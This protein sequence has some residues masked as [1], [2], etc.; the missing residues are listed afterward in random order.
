MVR[1]V[2]TPTGIEAHAGERRKQYENKKIAIGRLRRKL[3]V[4][5]RITGISVRGQHRGSRYQPS[6]LW[7]SRR[8]GKQI[9]INPRHA[10]FPALLAEALD[11]VVAR[12]G[13]VAGAAGLLGVSMSQLA[14]LFRHE[15]SAF[16]LVNKGREERGLPR[17]K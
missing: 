2:H 15:R 13:D 17:L 7:Q 9:S 6:E 12:D 11:V 3:A 1:I 10:D 5:V 8:Q 16:A 4:S 14:K